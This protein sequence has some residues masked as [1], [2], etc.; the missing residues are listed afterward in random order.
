MVSEREELIWCPRLTVG[1]LV[2]TRGI[3][4][5][6]TAKGGPGGVVAGG[7]VDVEVVG[8][9][10][11]VEEGGVGG[12]LLAREEAHPLTQSRAMPTSAAFR[13]PR[14]GIGEQDRNPGTCRTLT[15]CP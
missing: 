7:V 10:G 1:R 8:A 12:E 2:S 9:G 13:I 14:D 4:R 6:A 15:S 3:V 5:D 11:A